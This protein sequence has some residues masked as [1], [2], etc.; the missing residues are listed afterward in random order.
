MPQGNYQITYEG[1]GGQKIVRDLDLP[2]TNPSDSLL[3]PETVLPRT[4]FIADLY[5]DSKK[6]ISVVNGDAIMFPLKVE[7]QSLLTVEHWVDNLLVSVEQFSI[8]DSTFNYSMVPQPGDNK[9]VFTLRDRFNN[10]TTTDIFIN[11]KKDITIQSLIQ[12]EYRQAM[13]KKQI[14]AFIEMLKSLADDKLV[15]VIADSDIEKQEFD[16]VD[17]V[18]S[19]LKKEAGKKSISPEELDKLALRVAMMDNVLTQS[20]VDLMEKYADGDLKDILANLDIYQSNLK[21]WTD[22][23][24]YVLS[25][26]GGKISP[27]DL[28]KIAADILTEIDPSI[29]IIRKKILAFS[30]KY[31]TGAI[32]RES[33]NLTDQRNIKKGGRWLQSVYNE[34]IKQGLTDYQLSDMLAI[35][36][37]LPDTKAEQFLRDLIEYA[38]EPVLSSLKSLDLKKGK[39][40]SPEDLIVFII[41]N[42][43]KKLY[44]EE[45][46]FQCISSLIASKD[47][48]A[49]TI[50]SHLL[51]RKENRLWILWILLGTGLFV[52]FLIFLN[53]IKKNKK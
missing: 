40:K 42:K 31:E 50:L 20:A 1:F 34:S 52:F 39:I 37:S 9:I 3:L 2:I 7:P 27:E 10:T 41:S 36:S 25:K 8:I 12:Q 22:L 18:I 21:S 38:E 45:T 11:R 47:I 44:P 29:S 19:Y 48:P 33:V 30:E 13:A 26:S 16:K 17:N 43:D 51:T 6:T 53:K 5:V 35:I 49:D 24:K 23:Q 15:Q 4:D 32:L 46:V 28:N 14:A